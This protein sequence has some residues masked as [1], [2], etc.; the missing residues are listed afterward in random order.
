M[1]K[2]DQDNGVETSVENNGSEKSKRVPVQIVEYTTKDE[3]EANRPVGADAK[4]KN[5]KFVWNVYKVT[6]PT[7]AVSYIWAVGS[8]NAA[9]TVA[10]MDGYEVS[11]GE[12]RGGPRTVS[13][14]AAIAALSNMTREQLTALGLPALAIDG[15]L[16]AKA[17]KE[18][19]VATEPAAPHK[20]GRARKL[21]Q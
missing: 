7:K 5:G 14:T 18:T 20:Q 8:V 13:G 1:A 9:S 11:L 16:A 4:D 3:C 17:E 12:G 6:R 15:I 19:P 10:R 21:A 2:N